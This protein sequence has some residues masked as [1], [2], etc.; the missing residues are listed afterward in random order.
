MKIL[1]VNTLSHDSSICL[2]DHNGEYRHLIC[3]NRNSFLDDDIIQE[4]I[5]FKPDVI[6]YYENP[7]GKKQRQ[8]FNGQWIN[9]LTDELPTSYFKRIG[10]GSIPVKYQF[11]HASHAATG[12]YT[13]G[14]D[15]AAILVIDAIGEYTTTSVWHG[16]NNKLKMLESKDYPF[17]L[18]LFY[19]A[20]TQ[21]L[22]FKPNAEEHK[23]Y[24]L[25]L[26]ECNHKIDLY[27]KVKKYLRTNNH[28][29]IRDWYET[30]DEKQKI[31]IAYCVQEIFEKTVAKY[32]ESAK[33]LCGFPYE[34]NL[35]IMGGCAAN[36]KAA[37][38][39]RRWFKNIYS[40]PKPG[41]VSSSIGAAMLINNLGKLSVHLDT[42]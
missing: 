12:F 34:E 18:G 37:E 33:Q 1:G 40:H 22:G 9:A 21:L 39:A 13:S 14:F 30:I 16:K 3:K 8:L 27:Y 5:S 19:S 29:G 32:C 23:L 6:S 38:Q 2:M 42:D 25:S 20:F 11:H 17:S 36:K 28:R 10:L 24:E 15:S 41:D 26:K 4:A 35:V 31:N 7:W